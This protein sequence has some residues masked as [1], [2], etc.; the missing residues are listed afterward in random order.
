MTSNYIRGLPFISQ[1]GE[2]ASLRKKDC[3]PACEDMLLYAYKGVFFHPDD[4]YDYMEINIDMG[5]KGSEL[6]E[7]AKIFG[8][9]EVEIKNVS[10]DQL[11]EFVD[12]Q[13]PSICLINYKP[14]SDAGLTQF[15]GQFD[16]WLVVVGYVEAH[17]LVN[18]P[19]R[20]DGKT[21]LP[22]PD[23]IFQKAMYG[24]AVVPLT[25]V[26]GEYTITPTHKVKNTITSLTCRKGPSTKDKAIGYLRQ[27]EEVVV[28]SITDNNWAKIEGPRLWGYSYAPNLEPLT[29]FPNVP[30]EVYDVSHWE[31]GEGGRFIDWE[32]VNLKNISAIIVKATQGKD[33]IDPTF[34]HNWGQLKYNLRIKRGAFHYLENNTDPIEQADHF[35]N[36]LQGDYGELLPA[37]DCE[38]PEPSTNIAEKVKGFLDHFESVTGIRMMIYTYPS[39]W[40][41][42]TQNVG[43]AADYKLWIAHYGVA[44]PDI[45]LPWT[46][47]VMWQFTGDGIV[48]GIVGKVDFNKVYDLPV[49]E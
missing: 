6:I 33:F 20:T 45:P 47:A 17:I 36:T 40:K 2:G 5:T 12:Q 29:T 10:L 13:R 28:T 49:M 16:H 31:I 19:Y 15:K 34:G 37:L 18:D 42:F 1:M 21:Y 32:K 39:W 22:I 3:G 27:N 46:K 43:W 11:R 8:L 23:S 38:D 24:T 44:E 48:Y 4:F 9:E 7:F 26:T 35:I 25:G 30:S 14:L 41:E